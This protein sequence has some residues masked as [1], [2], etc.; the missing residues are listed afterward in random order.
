MLLSGRNLVSVSIENWVM[1]LEF[2][3]VFVVEFRHL[4]GTSDPY[5]TIHIMSSKKEKQ[6]DSDNTNFRVTKV[7]FATLN[8]KWN[9]SFTM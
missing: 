3:E 8:P 9:E 7:E 4:P 1:I 6:K 5:A 2:V